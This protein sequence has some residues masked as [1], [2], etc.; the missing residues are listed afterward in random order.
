M[1]KFLTVACGSALVQ[2]ALET[3][4]LLVES[5][6]GLTL[7]GQVLIGSK[8]ERTG[9]GSEKKGHFREKIRLRKQKG[10]EGLRMALR[11]SRKMVAGER[12]EP[13]VCPQRKNTRKG[14]RTQ[15]PF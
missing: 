6:E 14:E 15:K 10:R 12:P 9:R 8:E 5:L 11:G 3:R 4:S 13:D 2:E 7:K 1:G